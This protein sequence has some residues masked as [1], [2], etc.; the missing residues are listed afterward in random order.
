MP[1]IYT[2]SNQEQIDDLLNTY[3]SLYIE[4]EIRKEALVRNIGAFTNF[5][6]LAAIESGNIINLSKISADI[7]VNHH[8]ISKYYSILRECS[9][10]EIIEPIT[11]SSTRKRLTKSPKY[12]LA[13]LGIKRV[14]S[15][16]PVNPGIKLMGH[17]FEQFI[18]LELH[19]MLEQTRIKARVMY[20][21]SHD[22]PEVDYV[23]EHQQ[24]FR[25]IEVKWTDMPTEKDARHLI[26]FLREYEKSTNHA[27]IVCRSPHPMQ[28][29]EN[30]TAIPWQNLRQ[31]L[32]QN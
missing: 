26:T 10:L 14:G 13:D 30:V 24:M 8:T 22:G 5:F 27:Y 4:E 6:R 17:L 2:L 32:P 20:W 31:V 21:R 3:V 11:K 18:G 16:E 19:R 7:G 9:L 28:I 12:I 1:E 25:P 15:D 23:I 29:T